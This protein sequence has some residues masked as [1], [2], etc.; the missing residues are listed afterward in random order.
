MNTSPFHDLNISSDA[1][2]DGIKLFKR[3]YD[4]GYRTIAVN[5]VVDEVATEPKG[6][7][8]KGEK[9]D[10]DIVPLPVVVDLPEE[11]AGRLKVLNRL[12]VRLSDPSQYVKVA[13]SENLKKYHLLAVTPLNENTFQHLCHTLDVDII[14]LTAAEK[15]LRFNRKLYNLAVSKNMYFE[16]SY[17]LALNS[18]TNRRDLIQL[19]H[20]LHGVGKSKNIII[21][22]SATSYLQIRGPYEV[23]NLGLLFGLSQDQAKR[24][25][26]N[27]PMDVIK[28]RDGRR[29]GKNVVTVMKIDDDGSLDEIT[30]KAKRLK[31][32]NEIF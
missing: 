20:T 12:T 31:K 22:S 4:F 23:M 11:L 17:G 9:N 13:Q 21:T 10:V 30:S 7:K 15:N 5:Q 24:A 25:I 14:T 3:L 2:G 27:L 8:R 26:S 18:S 29:F 6:K 28:K 19:S 16:L 1:V 32:T